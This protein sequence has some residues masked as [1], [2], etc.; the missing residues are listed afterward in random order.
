MRRGPVAW[1]AHAP[2]PDVGTARAARSRRPGEG[3]RDVQPLVGV[4]AGRREGKVVA[5]TAL[6]DQQA[7][8][9]R[10]TGHVL[11]G[12][13]RPP[14]PQLARRSDQLHA[15]RLG[16]RRAV[17]DEVGEVAGAHADVGDVP[18]PIARARGD[19][20]RVGDV[21]PV[22]PRLHEPGRAHGRR[23]HRRPEPR[24][25][26]PGGDAGRASSSAAGRPA[27]P[28]AARPPA[29]RPARPRPVDVAV[30]L[31]GGPRSSR[32]TAPGRWR[33]GWRPR[34]SR[35]GGRSGGRWSSPRPGSGGPT[36]GGQGAT[37]ASSSAPSAR[38]SATRRV[39]GRLGT[40]AGRAEQ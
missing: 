8:V 15:E 32:R 10:G 12:V 37:R 39:I 27:T 2:A 5:M 18:Q 31:G 16:R 24:Q 26:R 9:E 33:P 34:R 25:L 29:A 14:G 36:G 4:G 3:L 38:R 11:G 7:E 21:L 13:L 1:G 30:E 35:P 40:S 22:G 6:G 23:A 19:A 20:E 17:A 28:R